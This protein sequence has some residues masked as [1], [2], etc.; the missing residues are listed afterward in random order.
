MC[1]LARPRA[2]GCDF[3]ARDLAPRS[4][5]RCRSHGTRRSHAADRSQAPPTRQHAR[6]LLGDRPP[7]A[8]AGR[9]SRRSSREECG[10]VQCRAEFPDGERDGYTESMNHRTFG[11]VGWRVGEVGYGMW[12]MGGWSGSKDEQSLESLQLAVDLGCNFFDT[13]AAYGDGRS[14]RLLGRLLRANRDKTLYAATKVAPKNR[15]WP[16]RR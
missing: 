3:G 2:R 14:E 16:S 12:G 8:A 10:S 7:N 11:R 5:C 6:S 1:C 13:A 15:T 9:A 4:S